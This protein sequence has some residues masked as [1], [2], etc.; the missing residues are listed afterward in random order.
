MTTAVPTLSA[1]GFVTNI[2]PKAD[3]VVAYFLT[4]EYSQS[5]IYY[6][7]ITSL[8]WLVAMYGNVPNEMT[9]Q[10]RTALERYL[11]RYFEGVQV[12]VTTE[13]ADAG[14]YS[15]VLDITV[16][17]NGKSYSLGREIT[18]VESKVIQIINN[19]NG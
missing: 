9:S 1:S 14:R 4:S 2:G 12:N 6:K 19:L 15:L 13:G 18:L 8:N 5:D 3:N 16:T 17:E 7:N 11:A 10:T